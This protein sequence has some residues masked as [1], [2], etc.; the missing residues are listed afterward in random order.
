MNAG[1]V[2]V[3]VINKIDL[4]HADIDR[5][6]TQMTNLFQFEKE[7]I[8]KVVNIRCASFSYSS[9]C[10]VSA[11]TGEGVSKVLEA[12]VANLPRQFLVTIDIALFIYPFFV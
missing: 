2:V 3:P 6:S 8:L 4:K 1:L 12:I 10:K 11:K 5:V 7:E 9:L